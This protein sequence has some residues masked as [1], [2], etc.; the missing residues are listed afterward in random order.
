MGTCNRC[1]KFGLKIPNRFGKMSIEIRG[2]DFLTHT[3]HV[4]AAS[5]SS[6]KNKAASDC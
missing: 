6:A 1:V 4:N 2:G 5:A 3:V